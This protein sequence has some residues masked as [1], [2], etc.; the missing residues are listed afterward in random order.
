MKWALGLPLI[1]LLS[2]CATFEK[3]VEQLGQRNADKRTFQVRNIW[4]RNTL[5]ETNEKY[6]KINRMTPLI[7]GSLLIQGNGLDGLVAYDRD[8]GT[9]KWRVNVL[10]G[11][12]GGAALI[13]DRIFFGGNDGNF[14]SVSL[15]DG[16]L[17]WTYAAKSENLSEPVVDSANGVVYFLS[18][19]NVVYALEADSGKQIWTYSRQDTSNFSVRG[20]TKPALRNE[21]LYVGFSEG[22]LIAFNA[23]SGSP[24]WELQ[25]NKNKRF[26]DIDATPVLDGDLLYVSG[27]DDRLYCIQAQRGEI[28]WKID[29]G[30]F[31]GITINGDKIYYPT[32]TGEVWA[33]RKSDGKKLW[34]YPLKEGIP[35]GIRLFNGLVAFG[36]SQGKLVF[37]DEG[38]GNKIGEFEPG[39]GILST[40]SIDEK[41]QRLYF[42][43][44]EANVYAVEARWDYP[45][46]FSYLR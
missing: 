46:W 5:A 33:L 21:L 34:S 9:E 45:S 23:H 42:I 37:L 40:P 11:V 16:K 20:G 27:Y 22:S 13:N 10:N 15:R 4:T 29:G 25:L 26:K 43:S 12:E 18:G 2:S 30:G 3:Q 39:R 36:E 38:T 41:K 24:V 28:V 14:Y 31:Y 8:S 17:L 44:G 19:N 7:A 6:R 35:T 1:L 32:S